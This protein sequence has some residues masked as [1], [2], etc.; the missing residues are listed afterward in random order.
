MLGKITT[1]ILNIYNITKVA[2]KIRKNFK[3]YDFSCQ[4]EYWAQNSGRSS[5]FSSRSR[6]SEARRRRSWYLSKMHSC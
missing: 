3:F 5:R 1:A 6:I 4:D 2:L